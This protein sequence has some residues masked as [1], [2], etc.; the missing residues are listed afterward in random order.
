MLASRLVRAAGIARASV[1]RGFAT[2]AAAPIAIAFVGLGDM[3]L[4]LAERV[5][6]G[7]GGV[8][9]FDASEARR[10]L[11]RSRLASVRSDRPSST[12]V[13]SLAEA[14]RGA[15]CVVTCLPN[16]SIVQS[17]VEEALGAS[18]LE[19][20][21]LWVDTTSGDPLVSRALAG[22]LSMPPASVEF[23]DCAVSGGPRGAEAGSVTAMV[24]GSADGFAAARPILETFAASIFHLGP[25][26][27]GHAVKAVNN[28]LMAAHIWLAAEGLLALQR[29]GVDP[30]AAN[31]AIAVSSGRSWATQQRIP[32]HVLP[33]TFDYGFK[34][35]LLLKDIGV[36][37]SLFTHEGAVVPLLNNAAEMV[38]GAAGY[39]SPSDDH[40]A[41]VRVL[42]KAANQELRASKGEGSGAERKG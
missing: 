7:V 3:G 2:S 32:Q 42:E 5:V 11:F 12:V 40:T 24:G 27:A 16:S 10:E 14:V 33:G 23:V 29:F 26:G 6:R 41:I 35:E 4:P 18:A 31:A 22:T 1:I 15:D 25:V 20:C 9:A 36:A 13:P 8:R 21:K 37:Q 19:D 17:V 28:T 38:R 39:L 34:L 30:A